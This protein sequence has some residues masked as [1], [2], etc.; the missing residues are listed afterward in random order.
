MGC[1]GLN[2]TSIDLAC[3]TD[4]T[5]GLQDLVYVVN[6]DDL[7]LIKVADVVDEVQIENYSIIEVS[8]NRPSNFTETGANDGTGTSTVVSTTVTLNLPPLAPSVR[9]ALNDYTNPMSRF[10]VVCKM[11]AKDSGKTQYFVAGAHFGLYGS[12]SYNSGT[13]RSEIAEAVLT[14]TG[15]EAVIGYVINEDQL[16]LL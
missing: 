10:A 6:K 8:R 5:G 16:T 2:L 13:Q 4:S 15:E 7:N 14:F 3:D 12:V 9:E 1:N 11:A